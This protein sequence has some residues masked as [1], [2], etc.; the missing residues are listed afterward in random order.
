MKL[1]R[2]KQV[3]PDVRATLWKL[4]GRCFILSNMIDL[5]Y[6]ALGLGHAGRI[7]GG[8]IKRKGNLAS[9]LLNKKSENCVEIIE[10]LTAAI[11]KESR[12]KDLVQI[13]DKR[14]CD[15]S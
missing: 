3:A 13:I 2:S 6:Q 8:N 4:H 5:I 9:S 1:L 10:W 15:C 14:S 12:M 11:M 7:D